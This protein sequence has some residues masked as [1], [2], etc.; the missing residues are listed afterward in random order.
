MKMKG[1][2]FLI[3]N[4]LRSD[5]FTDSIPIQLCLGYI[6][7]FNLL[8]TLHPS[9]LSLLKA[10]YVSLSQGEKHKSRP[11]V[12]LER[13]PLIN[14]DLSNPAEQFKSQLWGGL[15]IKLGTLEGHRS[16]STRFKV[17]SFLPKQKSQIPFS[18]VRGQRKKILMRL[19]KHSDFILINHYLIN[20]YKSP[21]NFIDSGYWLN[22]EY[23]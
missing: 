23:L 4:H 9:T 2:D 12:G 7:I 19:P 16:D 18:K 11:K 15:K 1:S 3:M 14:V 21:Y 8:V 22:L 6:Q 10:D 13:V 20:L 17:F 5:Q